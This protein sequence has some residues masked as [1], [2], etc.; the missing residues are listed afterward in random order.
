MGLRCLTRLTNAFDKKVENHEHA[1]AIDVM[2][3]TLV[4]IHRTIQ[5][6]SAMAACAFKTHWSMMDVER[7]VDE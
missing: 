5:V 1:I 6:T 7:I 2:H 3:Y 4:R